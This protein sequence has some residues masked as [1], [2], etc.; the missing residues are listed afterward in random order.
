MLAKKYIMLWLPICWDWIKLIRL[1]LWRTAQCFHPL[2]AETT[3]IILKKF[4]WN[5]LKN[6]KF[7]CH[8]TKSLVHPP[9]LCYQK[10]FCVII[11]LPMMVCRKLCVLSSTGTVWLK[12]SWWCVTLSFCLYNLIA[13]FGRHVALP[14]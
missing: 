12:G 5:P 2:T 13:S 7:N 11:W 14:Q 6:L 3:E 9:T 4:S 8:L 10:A 1:I